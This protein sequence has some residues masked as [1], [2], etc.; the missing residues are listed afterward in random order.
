MEPVAQTEVQTRVEQLLRDAHLQRMRQQWVPAETLCRQ[1]LEMAPRDPMGQ[2]L[3]G[4][5]LADKGSVDEA[6]TVYR[7]ALE[8]QPGKAS[9]EEKIARCV[10]QKDEEER[11]RI[12]AQLML[13][14]PAVGKE[15]KRNA[16]M[17]ILLSLLCP[18]AGQFFN[19]QYF[20]GGL[21]L[22]TGLIGLFF[23]GTDMIRMLLG[24]AG[25]RQSS[26]PDGL[27]VILGFTGLLAWIYSLLDASAQAG[28]VKNP[29]S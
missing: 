26:S 7:G 29:L 5:L 23:G 18:G 15:R 2:E 25:V 13:D 9:L 28:K 3:L 4:D 11:E 1:A 8:I 17:A 22:I 12:A 27:L 16:I 24:M 21:L 6:L 20:K 10:L 14:S 19:R